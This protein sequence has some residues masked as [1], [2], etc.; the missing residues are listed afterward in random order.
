MSYNDPGFTL[1]LDQG[2]HASRALI[3]DPG[4]NPIYSCQCEIELR[5][6][7]PHEV[8]QDADEIL[9]SCR[10]VLTQALEFAR[11]ENIALNSAGVAV[12]RSTVVAWDRLTGNTL[13]TALSWQD[14]R[15]HE[16]IEKLATHQSE[17]HALTGLRLSAHYGA[18]KLRWLLDNEPRVQDAMRKQ[19]L[20]TGPLV[21][22]ILFHVLG[23]Q[24]MLVDHANAARTLLWNIHTLAWDPGLL[25]LFDIDRR[26][27]PSCRP[28]RDQ[29]GYI[30]PTYIPVRAV[31]GD[32]NAAAFGYGPLARDTALINL[33][34]GAFVLAYTGHEPHMHQPLLTGIID[35]H[36]HQQD[37]ILEGTVN[38]AGAALHWAQQHWSLPEIDQL[39]W[40]QIETPPVFINTVAG[41]GSPWWRTGVTPSLA[42]D[43][44]SEL[45]PAS[46]K[47][48]VMESIIFMLQANIEQLIES[49][50]KLQQIKLAGGLS[51]DS[52]LCQRLANLCRMS[53]QRSLYK[54]ATARGIAW[55]AAGRPLHWSDNEAQIFQPQADARLRDRYSVFI[56]ELEKL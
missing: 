1:V 50:I 37:Y 51:Q 19:R 56:S 4:G 49:G 41:L 22:F 30:N 7:G 13:S 24:E 33:G 39:K 17:V 40:A 42:G 12:Q 18:S 32:Q 14:T 55:L 34:T 11:Q 2:T 8:E 53:V 21:S 15:A 35:S 10:E 28:I 43:A 44:G 47:A 29:Y 5:R 26:W 16:S 25:N 6:L 48:A 3:F 9:W 36:N 38:G 52:A 23:H 20:A 31:S 27:L 46:R 54:E 45:S